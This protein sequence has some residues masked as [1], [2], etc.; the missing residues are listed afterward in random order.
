[1]GIN[2]PRERGVAL[3]MVLV[4]ITLLASVVFDFQFN[5][6]V[7]LQLAVNARDEIQAEYNARSALMMRAM[8]L[9]NNNEIKALTSAMGIDSNALTITQLLEMVPV[10]CG[11]MSALIRKAR[12]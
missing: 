10:E 2:E 1:P 3:L 8:L 12:D 4:L 9:K 6:R 5:S 11:L 7:D